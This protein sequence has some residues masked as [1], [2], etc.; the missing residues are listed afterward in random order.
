MDTSALFAL[1]A[2]TDAG[3]E[4]AARLFEGLRGDQSALLTTSYN[5]VEM[6]ALTA[7]RLGREAVQVFRE[8]VVP[9]L[10]VCWVDRDLHER[11]LDLMFDRP[12]G[13]S[14]VDAVSLAYIRR[15]RVDAV[16]A[17]DRDFEREG[18]PLL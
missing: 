4:R 8:D 2:S 3:H 7:K 14:L 10:D 1:L 18:F 5:L 17:L 15:S 11:G 12:A 13:V 6:Y 16:F 9:L